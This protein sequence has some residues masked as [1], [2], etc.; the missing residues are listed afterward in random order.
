MMIKF[1]DFAVHGKLMKTRNTMK[2]ESNDPHLRSRRNPCFK[3][4]KKS[5]SKLG[6]NEK[7]NNLK[8]KI[9]Y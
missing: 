3:I 5:K 7:Q 4:K 8:T 6:K 2:L 1:Y 9:D